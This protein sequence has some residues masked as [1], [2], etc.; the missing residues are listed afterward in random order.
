MNRKKALQLWEYVVLPH[1]Q[2]KT[3]AQADLF[4]NTAEF[5]DSAFGL[6]AHFN[7]DDQNKI[8]TKWLQSRVAKTKK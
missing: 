1:I 6:K 2:Q 5:E 7:M 3:N 4:V 8:Q